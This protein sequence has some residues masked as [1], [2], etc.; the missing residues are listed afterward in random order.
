MTATHTREAL[1]KADAMWL[2]ADLPT[3]HF[4][5]TSLAMLDTPPQVEKLKVMLSHRLVLHPRLTQ[6]V[7]DPTLSL[8]GAHW[9]PAT[10]FEL[11]AHIHRVALPAPAGKRELAAFIGDLVGQPIDLARPMWHLYAVEGPGHGGALVGRFHHSLGDGAAMVRMLHTLADETAD[12]WKRPLPRKTARVRRHRPR[13]A[14]NPVARLVGGLPSVPRLALQAFDGAGTIARLT[15][16]DADRPTQLRG[17]LSLLKGVAWTEP[18]PLDVVKRI[19]AAS[20][21]TVNDVVVSAIAGGLGEHLRRRGVDTA[22]LRIRA[23]VP[24]NLRAADDAAMTGNHFSLVYLELPVGVLDA[25][26]RLMRV[27][28]EMDRIKHSF[29]PAA[30]W[31]LV[32]GLGIVPTALE[33]PLAGFYAEK[34]TLVLTNVIG[35]RRPLYL[36]GTQLKQMTFW[37]PQTGGLGVGVSIYSYAGEVT[38]G[39]V[40]DR[41][42]ITAPDDVTSDVTRAFADLAAQVR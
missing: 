33:R 3:N 16:M 12:G 41:K 36:A 10:G 34:A 29:E 38:V 23:M 35:P 1:S 42:L 4:V 20:G 37:E 27:R 26:E 11:D 25:R 7:D 9:V 22:G 24:V 28:L 14:G 15:L 19:A 32:Q 21:T 18:I 6:V 39:V 31:I 8:G 13:H 30:G 17:S 5:I 40:A 2:H